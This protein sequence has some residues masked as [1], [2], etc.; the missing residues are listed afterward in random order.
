MNPFAV[1]VDTQ[2][3]LYTASGRLIY[4]M[5]GGKIALLAGIAKAGPPYS[6]DNGPAGHAR[7]TETWGMMIDRQG[8]LYFSDIWTQTVRKIWA[9]RT[10]ATTPGP[11]TGSASGVVLVNGNA[12]KGGPIPYGSKV[13]VTK[14]RVTLKADVGMLTASGGGGITA[15]FILVR[16][17]LPESRSSS[18]V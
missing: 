4:K 11:V 10:A 16:A 18:C 6:G 17:R 5:S 13:D 2:G 8:S 1:A 9:T 3:S 7:L 15:Q 14:G 12:Y